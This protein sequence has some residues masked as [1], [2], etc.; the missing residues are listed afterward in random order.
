MG[1]RPG[2]P[3]FIFINWTGA[4]YF[5]EM[6][7]KTGDLSDHQD[8]FFAAM[9]SRGIECKCARSYDQAIRILAGW[10]VVPITV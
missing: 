1:V 9:R 8:A 3:D 7:S 10:G 4:V 2:W 5:L 6:K